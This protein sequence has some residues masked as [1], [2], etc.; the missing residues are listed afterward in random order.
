[1]SILLFAVSAAL[2]NNVVLVQ[3]QG[4]CPFLGVS[5]KLDTALGMS[6]AVTFVMVLATAATWPI[7][8][9]VLVP[10]ELDYYSLTENKSTRRLLC[11]SPRRAGVFTS[12]KI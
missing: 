3:F 7:Y 6:A 1:M 11:S 8:T 10:K 9:F 2:V 12:Q 4:L 5:K